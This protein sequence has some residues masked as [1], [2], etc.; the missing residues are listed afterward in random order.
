[1]G[2]YFFKLA[3]LVAVMIFTSTLQVAAEPLDK[4]VVLHGL[5]RSSVSMWLLA[6]RL[7]QAGFEVHNLD[8]PSTEETIDQLVEMLDGE[9]ERCCLNSE[10]TVHFVTHSLGG[11]LVR[12]YISQKRPDNLGRVVMLSP[13]NQG[14]QLVDELRDNPLFQWATGPAGQ[15]LGTDPSNFPNRLGPADFEVGIITGTRSLNPLTSWLVTGEDD[16]KVSVES[17]QLEGM[18][19]FLVVPNTHTFIMNSSQVARE[20]VHFLELGTFST[21]RS[22]GQ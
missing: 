18:A 20:V 8:Y 7:T 9:V 3:L 11:I 16:G 17:A 10:K 15:E 4:V 5:G 13:P 6:S 14:T 22:A 19:D 2:R 21:E 1:M 12:A